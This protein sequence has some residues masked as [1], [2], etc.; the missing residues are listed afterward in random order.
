MEIMTCFIVN[1]ILI[2]SQH[3]LFYTEIVDIRSLQSEVG[4]SGSNTK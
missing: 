4:E 3:L 1:R 2:L